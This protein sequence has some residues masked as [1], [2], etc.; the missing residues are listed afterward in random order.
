MKPE[1][2][3]PTGGRT[4]GPGDPLLSVR[5]L[6]KHFVASR[7]R[8]REGREVVR[9]VDGVSFELRASETLGLVGESGSGKTTTAR[10]VL[11]LTDP[12]AGEIRFRGRSVADMDRQEWRSF[13]RSVQ[14][15]FQDPFSSLN[16]RMSVGSMLDEVL[17]VHRLAGDRAGRRAR[18]A[19]LLETVGLEEAHAARLPHEFSGGQRQRIGI[20]RALA[21]EP[22]LLVLDEPVSALD[23]SVRAQI[24]NLLQSLQEELGLAYLLIA[25][26]LAVVER[27]A[28]RVAVMYLGRIVEMGGARRVFAS[29]QHPYTRALVSAIPT[30]DPHAP[31]DR[32][33]SVLDGEP[34]GAVELPSGC[35][36]H[37]RCPH[38]MRDEEC[39]R[40]VPGLEETSDGGE[41]ACLKVDRTRGLE[42]GPGGRGSEP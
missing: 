34:P 24:L 12:T 22:E 37:P 25:H 38:P 27:V 13:R 23:V 6:K 11:G 17:R 10:L 8:W 20:A 36:F 14:L 21:V 1:V 2:E 7:V 42:A 5:G 29:P 15:V 16:P 18:V 33:H 26:D 35:P 39:A 41:V 30:L 32:R 4:A 40:V 19:R 31:R 28:H 9:A 3:G